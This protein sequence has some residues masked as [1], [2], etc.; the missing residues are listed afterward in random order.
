MT[1]SMTKP[2]IYAAI[3]AA[4]VAQTANVPA[5]STSADIPHNTITMTASR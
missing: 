5:F 1:K 4:F 2:L 3:V